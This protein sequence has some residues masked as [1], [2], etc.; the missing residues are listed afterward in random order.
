LK[1]RGEIVKT[2]AVGNEIV[3]KPNVKAAWQRRPVFIS[4]ATIIG[5]EAK[6]AQL[7]D[8]RDAGSVNV[9]V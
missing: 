8:E 7:S 4:S 1:R 5:H 6:G 9:G 2:G 3:V